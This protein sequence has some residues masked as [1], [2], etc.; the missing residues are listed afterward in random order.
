MIKQGTYQT[1][2]GYKARIDSDI[3]LRGI[4]VV[5]SI[6]YVAYNTDGTFTHK[7]DYPEVGDNF[8]LVVDGQQESKQ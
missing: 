5:F 3:E 4:G 7:E 6:G 1:K 8:D 2:G